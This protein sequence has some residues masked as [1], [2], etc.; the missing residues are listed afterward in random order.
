MARRGAQCTVIIHQCNQWVSIE[1]LNLAK[2]PGKRV[3]TQ[4]RCRKRNAKNNLQVGTESFPPSFIA[5]PRYAPVA[6]LW[7]FVEPG[8]TST[9][10]KEDRRSRFPTTCAWRASFRLRSLAIGI[11]PQLA[12][13]PARTVG[14]IQESTCIE[15]LVVAKRRPSRET[16]SRHTVLSTSSVNRDLTSQSRLGLIL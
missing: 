1:T 2:R 3:L 15:N 9:K 10:W 16:R 13:S 11:A 14:Q 6:H 7:V 5:E 8:C 12:S 4:P